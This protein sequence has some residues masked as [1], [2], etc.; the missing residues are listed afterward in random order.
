MITKIANYDLKQNYT[1]TS[2]KGI[3]G[4]RIIQQIEPKPN[5]PIK[6]NK[7]L[8]KITSYLM[9]ILTK[10]IMKISNKNTPDCS[11]ARDFNKALLNLK[12]TLE[13][14]KPIPKKNK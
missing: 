12:T 4:K 13:I 3:N 10:S 11:S 2:F 5:K 8:N 1:Q 7:V 6:N 14:F 9:T